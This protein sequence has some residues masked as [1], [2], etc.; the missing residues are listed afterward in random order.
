MLIGV[1]NGVAGHLSAPLAGLVQQTIDLNYITVR[2]PWQSTVGSFAWGGPSS[3]FC[4]AYRLCDVD[5]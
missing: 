2:R 4:R 5:V 1:A 3:G